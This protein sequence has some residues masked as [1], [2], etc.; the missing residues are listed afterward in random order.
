MSTAFAHAPA[1]TESARELARSLKWWARAPR[2]YLTALR[3]SA[4]YAEQFAG[5]ERYCT[6]VGYPRSGHT[7]IG[8]LLDAHPDIVI[9]HEL[10][11]FRYLRRGF[12]ERQIFYLALER[13]RRFTASGRQWT[14]YSYAVP[15]QWNGRFRNLKVIGDKRGGGTSKE[16]YREPGVLRKLQ[17]KI[18]PTANFV[19]VTRNPFDNI[20]TMSR[21]S[22]RSIAATIGEYFKLVHAV[23]AAREQLPPGQ[24]TDVRYECFVEAPQ[25]GLGAL[26][27]FLGQS[28]P[29]DYLRAASS[30]VFP[31]PK[32]SRD[33]AP[34]TPQTI[35][36]V[37]AQLQLH[38][39]LRGYTY[40]D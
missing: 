31:S 16:L 34:W 4:R 6:F 18:G 38:S 10:N 21:H 15:G 2:D 29:E 30:I 26:C 39:F 13:S 14:G 22:G 40:A 32:R 11:A 7:L 19:H 23:A 20:A 25:A 5:V 35:R 12:N 1:A 28:A 17:R 9:G 27:R 3:G 24:W 37:E 8:S 36:N 33:G